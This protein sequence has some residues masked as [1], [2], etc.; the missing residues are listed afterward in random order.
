MT[1]IKGLIIKNKRTKSLINKAQKGNIALIAHSDLDELAAYSLVECKVSA[2]INTRKS[3][4]GSYPNRGPGVL[5]SFNIPLYDIESCFYSFIN[6]GD[7]CEII[8]NKLFINGAYLCE[9]SPVI[10]NI[11]NNTFI[12]TIKEFMTNTWKYIDKEKD[13]L[14]RDIHLPYLNTKIT[15]KDVLLV[16]RGHSFK[17]DLHSLINYIKINEPIII[18]IDGGGD[19]L[20][21]EDIIPDIIIGD[22][23]SVSDSCLLKSKEIIVH[24]YLDGTAPGRYRIDKLGLEYKMFNFFG[25]SEDAAIII[26]YLSNCKNIVL[27][28]SHNNIIDFLEKGRKGMSSTTLIRS[29]IGDKIIDVKGINNIIGD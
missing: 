2:V 15:N 25:T 17:E 5:S 26:A 6:N 16:S 10:N 23:D 12:E 9:L 1:D 24:G 14:F 28:G 21:K 19:A 7:T 22:M 29:F 4:T 27:V 8:N 18:G 20:I 11:D 13:L 3:C